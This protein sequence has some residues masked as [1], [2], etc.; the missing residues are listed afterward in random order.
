MSIIFEWKDLAYVEKKVEAELGKQNRVL[1]G[2]LDERKTIPPDE[3][4]R[5]SEKMY[6]KNPKLKDDNEEEYD[7]W[8][9]VLPV[10]KK[11][12]GQAVIEETKVDISF[13]L[14]DSQGPN[15]ND[16]AM[17]IKTKFKFERAQGS[18]DPMIEG[19]LYHR[20]TCEFDCDA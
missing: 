9:L 13:K 18:L 12:D 10:L 14:K 20:R 15:E 19:D 6:F 16:L 2:I 3:A 4:K 7:G 1:Q 17:K 8:E 11:K 5:R